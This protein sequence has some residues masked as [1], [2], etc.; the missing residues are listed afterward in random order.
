M[1]RKFVLA[2]AIAAVS[3]VAAQAETGTTPNGAAVQE[4]KVVLQFV[5]GQPYYDKPSRDRPYRAPPYSG[6]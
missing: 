2:A 3:S 5:F 4:A 6:R 1:T